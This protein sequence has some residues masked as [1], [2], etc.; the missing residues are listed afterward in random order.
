MWEPLDVK[1]FYKFAE[2]FDNQVF[3]GNLDFY[4]DVDK[5]NMIQNNISNIAN[6]LHILEKHLDADNLTYERF[7][8]FLSMIHDVRYTYYKFSELFGAKDLKIDKGI[9]TFSNFRSKW[10]P[11]TDDAYIDILCRYVTEIGALRCSKDF[12]TEC[13]YAA[14]IG[15]RCDAEIMVLSDTSEDACHEIKHNNHIFII[16]NEFREYLNAILSGFSRLE[17]RI[18][19]IVSHKNALMYKMSKNK[20]S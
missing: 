9:F 8:L 11:H 16:V 2:T 1:N 7:A 15:M 19:Y 12:S 17:S 3:S 13:G 6:S 18:E 4:F 14:S 10:D 20:N 5:I